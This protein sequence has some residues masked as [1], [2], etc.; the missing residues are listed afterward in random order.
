MSDALPNQLIMSDFSSNLSSISVF[1]MM[2]PSVAVAYQT[3]TG[4][5]T[6]ILLLRRPICNSDYGYDYD[7]DSNYAD[8]VTASAELPESVPAY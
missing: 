8:Y 7:I 4:Q 6:H 5:T 2:V 1:L 3:Q